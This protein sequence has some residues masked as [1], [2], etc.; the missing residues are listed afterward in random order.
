[1]NSVVS[2]NAVYATK[3]EAFRKECTALRKL[4]PSY[5]RSRSSFKKKLSTEDV[6]CQEIMAMHITSTVDVLFPNTKGLSY[7]EIF[8]EG[9]KGFKSALNIALREILKMNG[10]TQSKKKHAGYQRK[11]R[12]V[13]TLVRRYLAKWNTTVKVEVEDK[14]RKQVYEN[15]EI[16]EEACVCHP[17]FQSI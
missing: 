16:M 8:C 17:F 6:K 3:M 2:D 14:K 1:M 15:E 12:K 9:Q 10:V 7:T 11:L 13:G 4:S 5:Q